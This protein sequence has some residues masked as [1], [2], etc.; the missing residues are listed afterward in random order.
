MLNR[1][2]CS[3][4][5]IYTCLC[6]SED[7]GLDQE[8]CG[9]DVRIPVLGTLLMDDG[10]SGIGKRC[11]SCQMVRCWL[12]VP[13]SEA[14]EVH[15]IGLMRAK[16]RLS[17]HS[18]AQQDAIR[19]GARSQEILGSEALAFSDCVVRPLAKCDDFT[20]GLTPAWTLSFSGMSRKG[21]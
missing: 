12:N 11:A 14:D 3:D 5:F 9:P 17:V 2:V 18:K 19:T 1:Y 7:Q 4:V 6:R 15:V 13:F 8:L 16:R 21:Y 20:I 10:K